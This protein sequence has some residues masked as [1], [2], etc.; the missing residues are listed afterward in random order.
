VINGACIASARSS[1]LIWPQKPV[2]AFDEPEGG[3][4]PVEVQFVNQSEWASD[5]LWDFG[6]GNRSRQENPV[7][8]YYDVG[9]W[10]VRLEVT[11]P[12]GSDVASSIVSIHETPKLGFNWSPDSVFVKDKPV[13][14]FN[15][16]VGA[17][18]YLWDFG[19]YDEE[20]EP[21]TGNFSSARDTSHIY[22]TE[23][24][25]D[26]KLVAWND[27]C[28]DSITETTVKVIPKGVL[29]F[30]TV[31]RPDPTGPNGGYIDPNDPSVDPNYANSIFFPG[32]NQQVS[33][34]HL[35]IYNRWGELIFQSHD[36]NLGWDGYINDRLAAQGVYFWKVTV[37]YKNG[38]PDSMAGDITLLHKK[39]Q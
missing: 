26:V 4:S 18:Y 38:H 11:G 27:Y 31:F 9:E 5:Y 6:D 12:G 39:E 32:V 21:A 17:D 28:I 29:E 20:G 33:E 19:D 37:V 35:Y 14:F 1:I 34:Y 2:A 10:T 30:P 3:C 22:F 8:T 24:Y 23:G 15:L 25:K 36:V 13:R 16:T 7:H